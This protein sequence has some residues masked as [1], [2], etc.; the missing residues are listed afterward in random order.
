MMETAL[1]G[2][3]LSLIVDLFA[4]QKR[5][6]WGQHS[7]LM[8]RVLEGTTASRIDD[9]QQSLRQCCMIIA[10]LIFKL[11]PLRDQFLEE[12]V[13]PSGSNQINLDRCAQ[14]TET[15]C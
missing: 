5:S 2:I 1:C 11:L 13:M 12:S 8:R 4:V 3:R 7:R 10:S 6:C 14:N 15:N 9:D